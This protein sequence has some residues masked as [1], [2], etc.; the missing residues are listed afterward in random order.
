MIERV[1]SVELTKFS[2]KAD[3]FHTSCSVSDG[4][5]PVALGLLK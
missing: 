3:D 1:D 5:I 2:N 4:F